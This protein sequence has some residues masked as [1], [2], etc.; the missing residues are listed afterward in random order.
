MGSDV[1]EMAVMGAGRAGNCSDGVEAEALGDKQRVTC[2]CVGRCRF[3]LAAHTPGILDARCESEQEGVAGPVRR[4]KQDV[5]A[6]QEEDREWA[7]SSAW[8]VEPN[9][10]KVEGRAQARQSGD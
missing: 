10:V 2:H 6:A 4:S 5:N 8:A 9:K 3:Q 1:S 7:G